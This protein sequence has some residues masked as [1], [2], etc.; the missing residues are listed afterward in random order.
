MGQIRVFASYDLQRDEKLFKKLLKQ[1]HRGDSPFVIFDKTDAASMDPA[2]DGTLRARL[3]RAEQLLV[4]CTE[5]THRAE[6]VNREVRIARE[7]SIPYFFLKGKLFTEGA[8]PKSA[9]IDD[10]I[11]RWTLGGLYS[12]VSGAR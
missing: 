4:I 9:L 12:L 3:K 10:R 5:W 1:S 11:Y 7:E 8:R 2:N 6:N